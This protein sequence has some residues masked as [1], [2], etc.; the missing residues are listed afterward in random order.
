MCRTARA[1]YQFTVKLDDDVTDDPLIVT[2]LYP[3]GERERLTTR[4]S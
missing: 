3:P 1:G 2:V 4:F